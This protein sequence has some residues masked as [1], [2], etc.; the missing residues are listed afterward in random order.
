LQFEAFGVTTD[1]PKKANY[2]QRLNPDIPSDLLSN[3][4]R[5]K[6]IKSTRCSGCTFNGDLRK[7][8]QQKELEKRQT[9]I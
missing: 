5:F 2:L 1:A 8:A 7:K 4:F 9:V 6:I 3:T